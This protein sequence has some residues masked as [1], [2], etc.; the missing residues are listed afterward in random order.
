[1]AHWSDH[2]HYCPVYKAFDAAPDM[3]G[4]GIDEQETQQEEGN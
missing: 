2:R 4:C 3:C 1:M